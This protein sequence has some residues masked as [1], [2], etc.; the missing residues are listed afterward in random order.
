MHEH[1]ALGAEF[2]LAS[3]LLFTTSELIMITTCPMCAVLR[4]CVFD[5]HKAAWASVG[6]T[7][8]FLSAALFEVCVV[9][10]WVC[11]HNRRSIG[12]DGVIIWTFETR[13]ITI[14]CTTGFCVRATASCVFAPLELVVGCE[15]IGMRTL[16]RGACGNLDTAN[17]A[18]NICASPTSTI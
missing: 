12:P 2:C 10:A 14:L 18:I 1:L 3:R 8:A 7:L 6:A 11:T 15:A 4:R 13:A 17:A 16:V 5:M 9:T